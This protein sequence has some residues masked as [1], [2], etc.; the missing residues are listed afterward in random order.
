MGPL[1][2]PELILLFVIALLVFGPKKLPELG[3][4]F[5]KGMAEF[6]RA[7]NELRSTFQT[8]MDNIE[9]ETVEVKEVTKEISADVNKQLS[10]NYD[11]SEDDY[12]SEY[13][14]TPYDA[15]D[16]ADDSSTSSSTSTAPKTETASST[17]KSNGSTAAVTNAAAVDTAKPAQSSAGA[18]PSEVKA[19]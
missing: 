17:G 8:E 7:S 13:D 9:R 11:D 3:R 10:T 14:D 6:R 18:D 1:G 2:I 15:G 19:G 16:S 4:T 5:G 12:Y